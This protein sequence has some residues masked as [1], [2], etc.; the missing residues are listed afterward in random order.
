MITAPEL[1]AELLAR[2]RVV[3]SLALDGV[4][5]R[6]PGR[7][8]DDDAW[9]CPAIG[10]GVV[11]RGIGAIGGQGRP[12]AKLAVWSLVGELARHPDPSL[13]ARLRHGLA[14]AEAAVRRLAGNWPEGLL[15]PCGVLAA[16]L[17]EGSVAMLAHVGSCRV[18]RLR[19]GRLEPLTRDH[20]LAA[21]LP[22]APPEY[23]GVLTRALGFGVEPELQR[24]PVEP[25]DVLLLSSVP[26]PADRP[27]PGPHVDAHAAAL[28]LARDADATVIVARVGA[29]ATH[30][31]DRGSSHAPALPWLFA[32]G[33]PLAEPPE[34]YAPGTAG[35]G[36]DARWFAEVFDGVL[37]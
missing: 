22:A 24:I 11:A 8:E 17:I 13:E 2:P 36:P 18:A 7:S 25:G 29:H 19:G 28:A 14:R 20:T 10:L 12:A 23:A 4:L 6:A 35:H 3:P 16:V 33:Q 21:E 26:W 15:R 32:P 30:A 31:S 5:V 9:L 1:E 34:R 27:D 37:R